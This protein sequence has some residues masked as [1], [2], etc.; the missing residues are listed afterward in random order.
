M[1]KN[2]A[3]ICQDCGSD[4]L[5]PRLRPDGKIRCACCESDRI[6]AMCFM[7]EPVEDS[8]E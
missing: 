3:L 7:Y 4:A 5:G 2:E 1:S 6:D 8:H